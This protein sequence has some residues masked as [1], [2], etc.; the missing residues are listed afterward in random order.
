MASPGPHQRGGCIQVGHKV[1]TTA[2]SPGDTGSVGLG[3]VGQEQDLV[4][5]QRISGG[6]DGH[7]NVG[8]TIPGVPVALN[9]WVVGNAKKQMLFQERCLWACP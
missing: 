8:T 7:P 1:A 2:S 5:F 3:R 4:C 9:L 6:S